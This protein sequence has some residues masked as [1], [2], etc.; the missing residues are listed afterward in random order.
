MKGK[1]DVVS[2]AA[3]FLTKDNMTLKKLQKLCYYSQA[4]F[5]TLK[6]H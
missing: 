1:Y 5:Y 4:W 3:W 2:I 6:K